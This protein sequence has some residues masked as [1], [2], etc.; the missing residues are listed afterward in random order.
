MYPL[1]LA[2]LSKLFHLHEPWF[3]H[4]QKKV[5]IRNSKSVMKIKPENA[6]KLLTQCVAES[7]HSVNVGY[8]YKTQKVASIAIII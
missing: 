1:S 4:L 6:S 2:F 5:I 7:K 8:G 3:I